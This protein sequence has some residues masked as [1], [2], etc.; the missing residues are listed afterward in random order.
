MI[1]K[2]KKILVTG[3]AGMIGR[4]VVSKL[5]KQNSLITATDL[6]KPSKY[7]KNVNFVEADLRFFDQCLKICEG[8]DIVI[9]LAGIKGSPKMCMEQPANFMIP[10]LQFNTNILEAAKKNNCE[11]ILYTSSVGVYSPAEIFFEDTVWNTFPSKND[12][13][14]GWA[15]RIG[16]L[17][18]Q[19]YEIQ[20]KMSN[21]SIIRPANVYGEFDNFEPNS[22]MVIPSL[23]R[24]AHENEI[25][26]VWGDG[27]PIRDF[28]HAEDV[29]RGALH[30]I[31]KSFTMPVNLGSSIGCSIKD[32]VEVIVS[33]S[34]K[35][36]KIKWLSDKP[37]GDKIRLFDTERAKSIG[38]N[39]QISLSEGIERTTK[40]F[41]ENHQI[42][43]KRFNAFE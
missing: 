29:A 16:E 22:S 28:I 4:F 15:K 40:W 6:Y 35:K 37:S 2:N 31:Q 18:A 27:S 34:I 25:L 14:A 20:D 32:L 8:I 13:F 36:P 21:I 23:I 9:H 41:L 17:Q 30:V 11:W 1:F 38:F 19:A 10:M 12:W 33:K 5:L 3:A 24:K 26:E 39:C 43:S 7:E 42:I